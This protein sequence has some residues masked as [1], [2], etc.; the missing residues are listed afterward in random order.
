MNKVILVGRLTKDPELRT[1]NNGK[2]VCRFTVAVDRKVKQEGQPSAD[3]IPVVAWNR[4]AEVISQ[5][6]VKGRQIALNGRLTTGSFTNKDGVK[7][8]TTEVMLDEFD[9]IS[10]NSGVKN[11]KAG[12][13]QNIVMEDEDFNIISDEEEV[14]F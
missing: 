8:Y 6:L 3:F 2:S 1:T 12:N 4:Q 14:P 5:Y 10:D 13:S 7:Q 11:G 9:F